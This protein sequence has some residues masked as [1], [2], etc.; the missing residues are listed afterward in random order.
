MASR[1]IWPTTFGGV[2]LAATRGPAPRVVDRVR[3]DV[4]GR[5]Q[6]GGVLDDVGCDWSGA[7]DADADAVAGQFVVQGFGE[8][9]D[10]EL[11][12]GV[13][14][15][16]GGVDEPGPG[17]GVDDV[18]AVA[19]FDHPRDERLD[20]VVDAVQ[21]DPDHPV[22]RLV[23]HVPRRRGT[24]DAGVVEQQA[25]RAELGFDL[26][27]N[28]GVGV[29]VAH[30]QRDGHR[31]GGGGQL[32]SSGVEGIDVDVGDG[33]PSLLRR[34]GRGRC[35]AR[36]LAPPVM[37]AVRPAMS[38]RFTTLLLS[39]SARLDGRHHPPHGAHR[40]HRLLPLAANRVGGVETCEHH[41][42]W[43]AGSASS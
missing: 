29:A 37:N 11:G 8:A 34:R 24:G 19:A 35:R 5:A 18:A 41:V 20:A 12:G 27:G 43:V 7:Q 23:A 15:P 4:V 31:R 26:V 38:S 25:D 22:P 40:E 17:R 10:A 32:A 2:P 42:G 16:G 36:C 13:E 9:D 39:G 30:V 6:L 3:R 28:A 33:D 21:V 1:T 14:E